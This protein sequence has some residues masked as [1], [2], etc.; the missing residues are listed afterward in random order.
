MTSGTAARMR[1]WAGPALL[2]FGFRPF[3]LFGCLW[4]A[5]AMAVWIAVLSGLL[6]LPSRFDPVA[7]HA[8]AFLFGYLGAVIGGFLLTAVPNWTGRLPVT[9]W[10]LGLLVL[11]WGAGRV[12][13]TVS[14]GLDPLLV[15]MVDL[16]FPVALGAVLLREILAGRNWR[17]LPVLGLL[18]VFSGAN[19]LFHIEAG[20]GVGTRLGLATAIM[21]IS[22]IGGR[23]VPRF[24]RN[25][26]VKRNDPHRPVPPMQGLDKAALAL[27]G[28]GLMLWTA[29]PENAASGGLLIV[30]G[31]VHAV[32]LARWQG[33]RTLAEPLLWV[34]HAGYAFVPL[35]ALTMGAAI[36]SPDRVPI[37]AAQHLWM[38]G[39]IGLMTIAVMTRATLGHTGRPLHA[40]PA[41]LGLY[42]ATVLAVPTR[43]AVVFLPDASNVLYAVSGICW[44]A[45][46][47]GFVIVY[48]PM[49]LRPKP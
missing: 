4:S 35:G 40:G 39:A 3:F 30:M 11:S 44:I 7:W 18:V 42:L 49:L 45:A 16:A 33:H 22:L 2:G 32:R 19:L 46:F 47:A 12:A 14:S 13:V 9:G 48:G 29:L 20:N 27:T 43:G 8:H 24:T 31:C 34:L 21:M 41:T 23:I 17:N 37:A 25:W 28:L 26:L 38:A 6:V 10:G 15:A 36:L 5:G 1:E